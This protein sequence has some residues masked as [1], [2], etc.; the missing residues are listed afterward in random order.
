MFV[1]RWHS[2]TGSFLP[3]NPMAGLTEPRAAAKA[4][5]LGQE[6]DKGAMKITFLLP[7]QEDSEL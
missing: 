5:L 1:G 6:T 2:F 3:E 7:F 4:R